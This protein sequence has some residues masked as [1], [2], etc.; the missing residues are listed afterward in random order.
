MMRILNCKEYGHEKY[1]LKYY[2]GYEC[3]DSDHNYY[4]SFN[5]IKIIILFSFFK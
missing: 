2:L 3:Y 1:Y 5:H 4:V